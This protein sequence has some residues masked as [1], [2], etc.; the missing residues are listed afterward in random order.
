MRRTAILALGLTTALAATAVA[1]QAPPKTEPATFTM[2]KEY[3]TVQASALGVHRKL[4]LSMVD[5]MPERLFRDKATPA[6]RDFAQQIHHIVSAES[7]I[8]SRWIA[9]APRAQAVG[10]TAKVFNSKDAMKAYINGEYDYLDNLM[11]TQADADRDVRVQFFNGAMIPKWQ[12]WDEIHQHTMWTAGQVVGNF[13]K[14]GMAPP[15]FLFF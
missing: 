10:D 1:Q 12:V 2:S 9:G 7:F 5:S 3:R 4:M 15:P 11:K 14:N 8:A 13:R 6:Q